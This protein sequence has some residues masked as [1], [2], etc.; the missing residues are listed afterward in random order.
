MSSPAPTPLSESTR[1]RLGLPACR[2]NETVLG[3]GSEQLDGTTLRRETDRAIQRAAVSEG[4]GTARGHRLG[5][6]VDRFLDESQL[7]HRF[8]GD[9]DGGASMRNLIGKLEA[10]N[11]RAPLTDRFIR[12]SIV[13]YIYFPRSFLETE[14]R[15]TR[16]DDIYIQI[17]SRSH[18][19]STGS[20]LKRKSSRSCA[21][22]DRYRLLKEHPIKT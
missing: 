16:I 18:P 12:I 14:F 21:G 10:V 20:Y 19:V 7:I 1:L 9:D 8:I 6:R 17:S 2:R 22:K 4:T 3:A 15:L 11:K 5:C 13:I